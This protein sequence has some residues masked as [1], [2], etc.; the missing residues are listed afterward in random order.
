MPKQESHVSTTETTHPPALTRPLLPPRCR[1]PVP[2][3]SWVRPAA[4]QF[5]ACH[6]PL[7]HP[8]SPSSA[9]VA[10]QPPCSLLPFPLPFFP[11]SFFPLCSLFP[12]YRTGPCV[13][14][15]NVAQGICPPVFS[16]KTDSICELSPVV[17]LCLIIIFTAFPD[18]APGGGFAP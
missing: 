3:C 4:S 14:S 6:I 8:L 17:L 5:P 15:L 13:L 10:P 1:I 9:I 18:P 12:F 2:S 16:K 7:P 11:S